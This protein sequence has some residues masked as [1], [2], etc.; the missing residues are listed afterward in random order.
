MAHQNI[1]YNFYSYWILLIVIAQDTL[2]FHKNYFHVLWQKYRPFNQQ[3]L[4][5]IFFVSIFWTVERLWLSGCK[6]FQIYLEPFDLKT[7]C[8]LFRTITTNS[9]IFN[10][11]FVICT[12]FS[13]LSRH[14]GHVSFTY[15]LLSNQ[16]ILWVQE[17]IVSLTFVQ[18]LCHLHKRYEVL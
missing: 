17:I 12:P 16:T 14:H 5:S 7:P 6:C 13:R 3:L 4:V 10:K 1:S 18:S 11:P 9:K 8:C 2:Q 15:F